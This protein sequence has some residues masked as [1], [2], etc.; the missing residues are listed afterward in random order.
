MR[1]V[2]MIFSKEVN[3]LGRKSA[4]KKSFANFLLGEICT[5]AIKMRFFRDFEKRQTVKVCMNNEIGE[6]KDW[7]DPRNDEC[8]HNEDA[9][10]DCQCKRPRNKK[11]YRRVRVTDNGVGHRVN[12]SLIFEIYPSNGTVVMREKGRK[13]RFSIAASDLYRYLMQRAAL[14]HLAAKRRTRA[15]RK[16]ARRVVRR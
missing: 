8:P 11:P 4:F 7:H 10:T 5:A 9:H 12:P 3:S 15:D 16:K 13:K 14:A 6:V 1:F 2:G